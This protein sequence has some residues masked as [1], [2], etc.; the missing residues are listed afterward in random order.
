MILTLAAVTANAQDD[1]NPPLPG[2]PNANYKVKVGISH[3]GAGSVNGGGSFVQGQQVT[4]RRTDA[5]VSSSTTTFYKFKYWTLNG[6][7]YEPAGKKS[8]FTYTIGTENATFEAVYEVE[9]PDNVTSKV[10][11]IAEPSDAC[12]FNQTS[13]NRYLEDNSVYLYYNSTSDAFK[14]KGWY[15]E[16][17]LITTNR[18][19]YHN[20]G[21]DDATIT[22]RFTY[23]PTIPSEP[24]GCQDN[25]DNSTK[26]DVNNDN[27]V[28]VQDVVACVNVVL[29]DSGNK[30]ADVNKDGLVDV[31]DVVSLVNIILNKE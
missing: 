4:I 8:S 27:A 28:D 25:V 31:Q 9:D 29:T 10:Y 23:E 5:Y 21:T 11:L 19:F 30:K 15:E 7:E 17:K 1:F 2:E 24:T 18:Y 14:F 26:G 6:E 3:S 12:T 22:A 20:V 13:G 16:D